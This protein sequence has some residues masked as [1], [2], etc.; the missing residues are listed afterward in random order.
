MHKSFRT[1]SRS[2]NMHKYTSRYP[3]GLTAKRAAFIAAATATSI[4]IVAVTAGIANHAYAQVPMAQP[5][6]SE[7]MI[8]PARGQSPLEQSRDRYECYEWAKRQTG[9][10]PSS[11]YASASM[12][13]SAMPSTP[14]SP[15]AQSVAATGAMV[16]GGA[17]G[18]AVA[19]LTHHDVGRGAAIGVLGGG[20]MAQAKQQQQVA[21]AKQQQAAQQ[22]AAQ[23]QSRGQQRASYDRA[24]GAC[25]EGRGYTVR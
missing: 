17:S 8:Y 11:S 7:P 22:Q 3:L 15:Q 21:V 19:E 14:M 12:P 10:D 20:L 23:Q 6:P 1:F 2:S 4:L 25:M 16:R 5:A 9:F 24:L 18:A 13:S